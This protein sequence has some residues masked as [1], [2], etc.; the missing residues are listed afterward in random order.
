MLAPLGAPGSKLKFSV[1]AGRFASVAVFVTTNVLNSLIIWSAGTVSRGAWFTSATTTMK[2]RVSLEGGEPSSVTRTVIRLVLGPCASVGVQEN[3][4]LVGLMLA[5]A[6]PPGSKL[7]V[8][9]LA[10]MS[11]SVA[12]FVTTNVLSS[13]IIWSAGTLSTGARFTSATTIV[14]LR[15]SL[16][17]G[18]PSS[19][20]RTV[21]VLVLGP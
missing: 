4:P 14:K 6:G 12:V 20:T 16:E 15:V 10:G 3:T 19:V 5:R 18:E 7:K 11:A 17:G 9:V 13:L 8:S 2:L 21:I 1:L